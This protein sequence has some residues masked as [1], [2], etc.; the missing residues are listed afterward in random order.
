MHL[1]KQKDSCVYRPYGN[2]KHKIYN[3]YTHTHTREE[4]LKTNQSSNHKGKEQKGTI[5]QP[6]NNYQ[7]AVSTHLLIITSN[8]NGLDTPMKSHW[9]LFPAGTMEDAKEKKKK[10][11]IVPETLKKK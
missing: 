7:L 4:N 11:P 9:V 5:K 2:Y 10:V 8:V 1:Y 3:R 6:P